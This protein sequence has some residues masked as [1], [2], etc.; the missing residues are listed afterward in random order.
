[1]PVVAAERF[2]ERGGLIPWL[3]SLLLSNLRRAVVRLA[4]PATPI[5]Y[6]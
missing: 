6:Q 5:E 4:D 3:E 2:D 1:L